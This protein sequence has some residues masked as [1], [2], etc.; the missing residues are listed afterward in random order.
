MSSWRRPFPPQG[1]LS[2]EVA[3]LAQLFCHLTL[4]LLSGRENETPPE[5]AAFHFGQSIINRK[6]IR[7][8]QLRGIITLKKGGDDMLTFGTMPV[9]V[10]F[11]RNDHALCMFDPDT[12]KIYLC[13]GGRWVESDDLNLREEI[14]LR[15]IELSRNEALR[16]TNDQ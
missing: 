12:F 10:K 14:R 4:P 13:D 3:E 16:G 8:K 9:S 11:F 1:R 6:L 7:A 15:S 2:P 5:K